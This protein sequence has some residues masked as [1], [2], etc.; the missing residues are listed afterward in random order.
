MN[1]KLLEDMGLTKGEIAVYLAL[2]RIGETTT[3]R[4][5]DE[6][7]ISSG[8]V[9]EIL[10]KL[11]KKGLVSHLIKEK[12]KYFNAASPTRLLEYLHEKE[13]DLKHKESALQKEIPN[14]LRLQGT[15]RKKYEA[16]MFTGIKGI[17]TAIFEALERMPQGEILAFGVRST[18]DAKYN[19]LWSSWH[20]NRVKKK[21][22]CKIL[23]SDK[24]SDYYRMFKSMPHTKVRALEGF[25]PSAIDILG[26][27]TLISTYGAEPSCLSITSEEVA[28]SFKTHF[29]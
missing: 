21:I 1:E 20:K 27:T 18:K 10:E 22:D 23:F 12:T 2:L 29:K 14:L 8:K 4:I 28:Q 6:A 19:K 3:G 13:R 9:Y 17:Q 16:T 24:G 25:T 15:Q 7:G 5:V 11:T 26:N